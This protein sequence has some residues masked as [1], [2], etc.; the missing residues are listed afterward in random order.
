MTLLF[1]EFCGLA[2]SS[3]PPHRADLHH[4]RLFPGLP[5]HSVHRLFLWH[6]NHPCDLSDPK[7][8]KGNSPNGLELQKV[9]LCQVTVRE[10]C[11]VMKVGNKTMD[12]KERC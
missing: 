9:I 8:S 2:S 10:I 12:R 7:S 4:R 6:Y 11:Y 3:G 5:R 1:I